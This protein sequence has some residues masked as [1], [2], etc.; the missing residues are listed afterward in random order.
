MNRSRARALTLSASDAD[1]ARTSSRTDRAHRARLA[2]RSVL[3]VAERIE[4]GEL[5]L[6][7]AGT[8]RRFGSREVDELSAEID[9]QDERFFARVLTGGVIAVAETYRDGWWTTP[10]VVAV[11]RLLVRNR[12]ALE[13]LDGRLAWATRSARWLFHR[14]RRNTLSG[15]RRNISEHYD[16]SNDFFRLLL[17]ETMTYSAGVFTDPHASMADASIAKIDRLCRK[18]ELGP[19]DHLLEIGTGWGAFAIRAA[20]EFGCRVT[21]TTISREQYAHTAARIEAEGLEGRIDLRLEDYRKL[22]GRFDAIVSVEM[23]EAVGHEYYGE[24]FRTCERLGKP[25]ARFAMQAITIADQH[26]DRARRTVDFIKRYIF[27]GSNIPSTTALLEA[28]TRDSDWRLRHMEDITE[29]YCRTLAEWRA[30]L[31]AHEDEIGALGYDR[32]FRRFWEFYLAYCEGGFAER[33]IGTIQLLW[34]RPDWRGE[35]PLPSLD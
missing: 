33:H 2:E 23:I 19:D 34:T 29:H 14:L 8:T 25:D 4:R 32:R 18:L 12:P 6:R 13:R 21:T 22:E 17:D 7:H 3:A 9:V 10:D 28:A 24:F 26:Y 15:S 16:L 30:N 5:T 20:Q 1:R 27:P 11:V 31:H 35:A